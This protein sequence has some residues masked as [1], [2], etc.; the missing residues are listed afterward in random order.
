[1]TSS[2]FVMRITPT[3]IH[4]LPFTVSGIEQCTRRLLNNVLIYKKEVNVYMAKSTKKAILTKT[5]N[6]FT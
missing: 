2:C 3:R 6:Q 5:K 1:M 4:A